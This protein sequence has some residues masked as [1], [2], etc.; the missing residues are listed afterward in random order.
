MLGALADERV[1]FVLIG[2]VAVAVHGFVRAT[3]DAD[4]VP[5]PDRDNLDRLVNRL[6]REEAR[7]A[8]APST[9]PISSSSS[10][11]SEETDRPPTVWTT[12]S[13]PPRSTARA[14]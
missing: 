2:G 3:D 13:P 10:E 9:W 1:D 4:I 8:L 6:I 12:R 5:A 7:L 11:K 14:G